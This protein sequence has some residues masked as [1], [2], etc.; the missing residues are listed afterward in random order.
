VTE[1][2]PTTLFSV[3]SIK[4]RM[5]VLFIKKI[6]NTIF[7]QMKFMDRG[8]KEKQVWGEYLELSKMKLQDSQKVIFQ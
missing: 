5:T 4:V 1:V 6:C 3:P 7:L 2:T 8:H